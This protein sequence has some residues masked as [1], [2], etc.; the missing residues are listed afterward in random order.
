M[1]I[2]FVYRSRSCVLFWVYDM[3]GFEWNHAWNGMRAHYIQCFVGVHCSVRPTKLQF[4][5]NRE[6]SVTLGLVL[7]LLYTAF[8]FS[9]FSVVQFALCH[10]G[11]AFTRT[12]H[13]LAPYSRVC[14]VFSPGSSSIYETY[15]NKIVLKVGSLDDLAAHL[16]AI[17]EKQYRISVDR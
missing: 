8:M 11:Q 15:A 3:L 14:C 5:S 12:L 7:W 16:S 6:S 2:L 13:A 1:S 9:A 4:S 10:P 17:P